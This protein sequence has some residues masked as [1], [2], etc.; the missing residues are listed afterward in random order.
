M[1]GQLVQQPAGSPAA[2][3]TR[4]QAVPPQQ[5]CL[6]DVQMPSSQQQHPQHRQPHWQQMQQEQQHVP[7]QQP[8][9]LAAAIAAA[10]CAVKST[11]WQDKALL[12]GAAGSTAAAHCEVASHNTMQPNLRFSDPVLEAAYMETQGQP[13]ANLDLLFILLNLAVM[14]CCMWDSSWQAGTTGASSLQQL[15]SAWGQWLLLAVAA[16]WLLAAPSSYGRWREPLWVA[17][18]VL[19]ALHVASVL[20]LHMLPQ[21]LVLSGAS[22]A[23][24]AAVTAGSAWLPALHKGKLLTLLAHNLGL[25][26]IDAC[27]D[28]NIH[29]EHAPLQQQQQLAFVQVWGAGNMKLALH[30]SGLVI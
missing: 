26:V 24:S 22:A 28:Q 18:R 14:A 30:A 1:L 19:S 2:V 20:L 27:W 21:R 7:K 13:L 4:L 5:L 3:G 29:E 25:K 15:L 6:Q 8:R 16:V 17:H 11:H 12:A 9:E 10:Q 23:V